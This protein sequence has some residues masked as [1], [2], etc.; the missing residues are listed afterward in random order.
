MR[1]ALVISSLGP[2]GAERVMSLLAGGLASRGH[3]V[4]LTTLAET[5]NDFFVVDPRVRRL[6]L[7]LLGDSATV[8]EAWRANVR[9]FLALRRAVTR[10]KPHV[11]LSFV[12]RMNVLAILACTGLPVRVLVSERVDAVG[13]R[14]QRLWAALRALVYRRADAVVVQTETVAR[15][16]RGRLGR[17]AAVA[18]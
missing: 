8:F 11:V 17:R 10:I 4:W 14:E 7:G 3:D 13:H 5:G 16:F 1:L 15:W 12:T 2:G 6:G 9:R 18:V